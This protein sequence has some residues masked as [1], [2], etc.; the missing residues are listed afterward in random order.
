MTPQQV[1]DKLKAM[2]Y[3]LP[4][5]PQAV[6][7]YVPALRSG[8][9]VYVSG[10]LPVRDG[11]VQVTGKLGR[12]VSLEAAQ[13]AARIAALNGLA[14][15]GQAAGGI[16]NIARIVRLAVFV[17][18]MPGFADQAKVANGASDLLQAVF[19]EAGR[20]V[21]VAVGVAALPL[22]AAVEIELWA[23]CSN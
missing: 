7:S 15:A 13:E 8:S 10:Q 20:H 17:N 11:K 18:S 6:G 5:V 22:D 2:G 14:A 1:T 3:S 16:D 19:G 12:D 4:D 23:E 9:M 21:R